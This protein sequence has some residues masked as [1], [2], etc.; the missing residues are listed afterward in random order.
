MRMRRIVLGFVAATTA[1]WLFGLWA[2]P[3]AMNGRGISHEV[4][5]WNGVLAWGFMAMAIVIAARP[6]WLERVTKT[7]LDELYRWHRT[8]GFWALGLSV[9]H[10]VTK[11][12]MQPILSLM[13]LDPVPKIVRGELAGFDLFWSQIRPF[14]VDS[15]IWATAI[16]LLLGAMVFVK[17]IRYSKW[18]LWHKL[19]SVLF[20]LLSVHS[21]RLMD[22]ADAFLPLGW[23]NIAV[24]LIGLRYSAVLLVR[25]AGR[26]KTVKA[27]VTD[28]RVDRDVTLLTVRPE[29]PLSVRPGEFAFLATDGEEKH[30]FSVASVRPDG[31]LLFAVKALGDYTTNTVPTIAAGDV[32]SVEGPWGAFTPAFLEGDAQKKPRHEVWVAGGIGIAPI[33]AWLESAAKEENAAPYAKLV[34]CIRD[35]TAEPL[36]GQVEWLAKKAGVDLRV[37]ESKT[38]RLDAAA[39]FREG[40]PESLALCAGAGLSSAV[41]DAYLKAGGERSAVRREHFDWR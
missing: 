23:I 3:P 40:L 41:I 11:T 16:A 30:P 36:F 32:V 37:V 13:T 17:A 35:R 7:P 39:L 22:P 6:A 19:F 26:E 38:A 5:Y 33:Y 27:A 20:I 4:F 10:W 31:T 28:V 8:L 2:D 21:I 14:A 25:G 9:V 29:K 12:L 1:A 15:S 18:L 34:W 24:T